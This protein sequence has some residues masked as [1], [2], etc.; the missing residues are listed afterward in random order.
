MLNKRLIREDVLCEQP[1][2]PVQ[3]ELRII[4]L[5]GV[6]VDL[7][8]FLR[9][10]DRGLCTIVQTSLERPSYI[11]SIHHVSVGERDALADM[12]D[13]SVVG[14]IALPAL[15]EHRGELMR[16]ALVPCK[17]LIARPA[18]TDQGSLLVRVE[19]FAEWCGINQ[20][21]A[22]LRRLGTAVSV[23]GF[24]ACKYAHQHNCRKEY[25]KNTLP[26]FLHCF[27]LLYRISM[28]FAGCGFA[29]FVC[30]LLL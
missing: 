4:D 30:R 19:E 23:A 20:I 11:R 29:S 2:L 15:S 24:A 18:V 1:E 8:D 16:S 14:L 17:R 3:R 26:L 28:I 6:I 27:T 9:C 10:A 13:E 25:R 21:S 7:L 12:N 22:L 5:N